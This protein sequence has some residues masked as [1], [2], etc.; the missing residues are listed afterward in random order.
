MPLLPDKSV[1]MILCDLPYGTTACKWDTIIPFE[2]LWKEYKRII[3]DNGA[4]VLTAS[5][6]FT[7]ALVM[8]NPDMFK[9]EWIWKKSRPSGMVL[10]KKQPMRNHE[11]ILV[12]YK[13]QSTYNPIM[14]TRE[15]F[16]EASKKMI[17]NGL[18]TYRNTKDT[19]RNTDRTETK[20]INE[21]RYPTTVKDF[22]SGSN[23]KGKLHPTQKPVALFEY[24]IKTY[25]NEGDLVLDNC[26]GSGTTGIACLNTKRNFILI[27]KEEK[28]VDIATKRIAEECKMK[29]LF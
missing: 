28:Y 26:A 29:V 13:N 21:L 15:Y 3:K 4:I 7:S 27:E 10:C 19:I 8:S 23:Q 6:P 17:S 2:P 16:T 12:F 22:S 11:N 25:T 9:Y 24:L 1:D 20:T 18:K 5:Q 14:E